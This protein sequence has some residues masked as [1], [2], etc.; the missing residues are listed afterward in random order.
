MNVYEKLMN[1]QNELVAPKGQFNSFGKYHYRSCEDI[2]E[3]LK[4]LLAK[5]KATL[6]IT[7][8]IV[9]IG[10]RHYVKATAT[11]I[12]VEKGEKVEATAYAREDETKREWIYLS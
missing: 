1:I 9:L 10:D 3:A 11:L 5:Y 12:D 4:P 8:E 2:V 6:T 7:D